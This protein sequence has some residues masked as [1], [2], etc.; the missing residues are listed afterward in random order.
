M[1]KFKWKLLT[2]LLYSLTQVFA[3]WQISKLSSIDITV[4]LLFNL[5]FLATFSVV[6]GP[7]ISA[8]NALTSVASINWFLVPPYGTFRVDSADNLSALIVFTF[9][10]V[11]IA[12]LLQ[13]TGRL[14]TQASTAEAQSE[15]LS[16]VISPVSG[17]KGTLSSIQE[18][19]DLS[20][21]T[22]IKPNGEIAV[23]TNEVLARDSVHIN[24]ENVA[25]TF[26]TKNGF[27]LIGYGN[28]RIAYDDNFLGS[29]ADVAVRA[30]ISEQ[31]ENE[32]QKNV[33][34]TTDN[35]FRSA[36]IA[37]IGHDLRTPL[38]T[39]R[40]AV[41]SLK[42]ET[43][44]ADEAKETI[45]H[46]EASTYRLADTLENLLDMSRIE[47][48]SILPHWEMVNVSALIRRLIREQSESRI[49]LIGDDVPPITSDDTLLERIIANVLGN[50]L[51]HDQSGGYVRVKQ[52][53]E[54]GNTLIEIIDQGAGFDP[55]N[56]PT[57]SE[58]SRLGIS[59]VK[60]F[61]KFLGIDVSFEPSEFG[62]GTH[63]RIKIPEQ[64]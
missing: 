33:E 41:D 1:F 58:G 5:L 46:L 27:D 17:L 62:T 18:Q 53:R 9:I 22:L 51:Q 36:L 52:S 56:L 29:L 63:V 14:R 61:S 39:M 13:L 32:I 55:N 6:T 28:P 64:K 4:V 59:I 54:N 10:S 8:C 38:A 2:G 42:H 34:L 3:M 23:A 44:N 37:S 30:Y 31:V 25:I 60:S 40:L 21:I 50:A 43:L 45:E 35:E 57:T 12:L 47:S 11:G 48:E 15:M 7:W 20:D 16:S 24:N 26:H 19:L 49:I